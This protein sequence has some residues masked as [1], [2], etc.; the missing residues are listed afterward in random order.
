[1]F[2]A[3]S[4]NYIVTKLKRLSMGKVVLDE[5]LA[6]GDYRRL[7]AEEIEALQRALE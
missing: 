5:N 7:S 2:L 3:L 4:E 1:M 6:P